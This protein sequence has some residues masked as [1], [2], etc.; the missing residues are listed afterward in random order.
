M[1][2]ER[3]NTKKRMQQEMPQSTS[4][5]TIVRFRAYMNHVSSASRTASQTAQPI[6]SQLHDAGS[7]DDE[8]GKILLVRRRAATTP[9]SSRAGGPPAGSGQLGPRIIHQHPITA[10]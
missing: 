7:M 9:G 1:S 10:K 6:P 3:T 2:R 8:G 4:R 5:P